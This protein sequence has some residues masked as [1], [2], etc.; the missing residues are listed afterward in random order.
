MRSV[1]AGD[2]PSPQRHRGHERTRRGIPCAEGRWLAGPSPAAYSRPHTHVPTRVLT[3]SAE[4]PARQ[5]LGASAST[6]R[7]RSWPRGVL[8]VCRRPGHWPFSG[9]A[10]P[11]GSSALRGLFLAPFPLLLPSSS[12]LP[13]SSRGLSDTASGPASSPAFSFAPLALGFSSRLAGWDSSL[14]P[15]WEEGSLSTLDSKSNWE[16][17][18]L[19]FF[20]F[21]FSLE[22][23]L[24]LAFESLTSP[25]LTFFNSLASFTSSF[26]GFLGSFGSS[27][28]SEIL[29]F[30]LRSNPELSG[31]LSRSSLARSRSFPVL[32][33][34]F[35]P[36]SGLGSSRCLN[37][38]FFFFGEVSSFVSLCW[39]LSEF[40]SNMSL[41]KESL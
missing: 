25:F 16:S 13:A 32:A 5:L 11:R 26:L 24:I 41:L 23:S 6:L 27:L 31:V 20:V 3:S 17:A 14:S 19:S 39:S 35:F 34:F 30:V 4:L 12:M 22:S 38:F 2:T 28:A 36:A 1:W 18:P 8:H 40:A 29:F 7:L 21:L 10:R 37:F 33:F 15:S 9:P